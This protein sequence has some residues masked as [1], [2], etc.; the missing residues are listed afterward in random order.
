MSLSNKKAEEL[1]LPQIISLL[2]FRKA[3]NVNL[4]NEHFIACPTC[5]N[6]SLKDYQKFCSCCGQKLNWDIFWK[7]EDNVEYLL[8]ILEQDFLYWSKFTDIKESDEDSIALKKKAVKKVKGLKMKIEEL[9]K[10][11]KPKLL[12]EDEDDEEELISDYSENE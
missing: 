7:T 9:E 1:T 5:G 8:D 11:L 6:S 2:S 4:K 10:I 3:K 12:D